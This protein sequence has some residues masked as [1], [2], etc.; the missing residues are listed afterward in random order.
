MLVWKESRGVSLI[1]SRVPR[2]PCTKSG[3]T[4]SVCVPHAS[5]KWGHIRGERNSCD[6]DATNVVLAWLRA[7]ASSRESSLM[8]E[9]L[10]TLK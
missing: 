8:I 6:I 10:K 1:N 5:G 2:M 7:I 9:W 3:C 4:R